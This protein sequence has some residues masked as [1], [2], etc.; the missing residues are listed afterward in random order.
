MKKARVCKKK[1]GFGKP[2]LYVVWRGIFISMGIVDNES[3][4]RVARKFRDRFNNEL[5]KEIS[6]V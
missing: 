2:A 4:W 6:G 3:G 1:Y 5:S